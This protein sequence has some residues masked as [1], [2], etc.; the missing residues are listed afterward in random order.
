MLTH[1][2]IDHTGYL[3][4]LVKNGFNGPIYC[5]QG[6]NDLCSILLPD[7]ANL[8]EEDAKY[9]NEHGYSKHTPAL[10]LYTVQDAEKAL[11][12]FE[13][14]PY[15]AEIQLNKGTYFQLIRSGH[16][17]GS[18]FVKINHRGASI[19]FTGDMG[20]MNDP[21]MRT[22]TSIKRDRLSCY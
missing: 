16:I 13:P 3:P 11:S 2:H 5:T 6:T 7:S 17:I 22:P 19:L 1:A 15:N 21:V 18:S 14:S 12:L 20:R 4:L 9:A 8:Q 10:P